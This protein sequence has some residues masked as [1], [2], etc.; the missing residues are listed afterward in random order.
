MEGVTESALLSLLG[1]ECLD[2]LQVEVVVK[3]EVVQVLSVDDEV[4]HVVALAT[5]LQTRL[6][7]I[8]FS[9][10]EELRCLEGAEEAALVEGLRGAVVK[11]VQHI[12]FEKLLVRHADLR[13]SNREMW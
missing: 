11:F 3:M 4:Q 6:D 13:V 12:A 7:P 5:D 8:D 2:R 10:L 1:R 9:R